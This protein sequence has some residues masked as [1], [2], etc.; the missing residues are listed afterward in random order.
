MKG[1]YKVID[2]QT[3]VEKLKKLFAKNLGAD[4]TQIT[5]ESRLIEDLGA[6]SL[7]VIDLVEEAQ[8]EFDIEIKD[9]DIERIKTFGDVVLCITEMYNAEEVVQ[10]AQFVSEVEISEINKDVDPYAIEISNEEE[11]AQDK[12]AIGTGVSMAGK[13]ID[14]AEKTLEEV[15]QIKTVDQ[16]IKYEHESKEYTM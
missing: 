8:A 14:N 6:D 2:E 4:E 1:I 16:A 10:G 3:I 12:E 11:A 15:K 9:E 7:D 13:S 5:N